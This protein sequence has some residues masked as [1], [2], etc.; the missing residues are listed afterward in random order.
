MAAVPHIELA[1]LLP[2][3]NIVTP[4]FSTAA[5]QLAVGFGRTGLVIVMLPQAGRLQLGLMARLASG[6]RVLPG[7]ESREW[8]LGG[9]PDA[10]NIEEVR[11]V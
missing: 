8:R 4:A 2:L 10:A 5:E 6:T 7:C 9:P 11:L 1:D 3:N